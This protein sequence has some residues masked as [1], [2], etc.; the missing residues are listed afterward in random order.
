MIQNVSCINN[1]IPSTQLTL[2]YTCDILF[3]VFVYAF[4]IIFVFYPVYMTRPQICYVLRSFVPRQSSCLS[5]LMFIVVMW[6]LFMLLLLFLL[7]LLFIL[8]VNVDVNEC[9]EAVGI[10]H[11]QCP[12][13]CLSC[14]TFNYCV[15]LQQFLGLRFFSPSRLAVSMN[16]IPFSPLDFNNIISA[17][18][19]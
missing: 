14:Y 2:V 9:R 15:C 18:N 6:L 17:G 13:I 19:V 3:L 1:I 11:T 10:G 16:V 7:L 12:C 8:K 5:L 4:F